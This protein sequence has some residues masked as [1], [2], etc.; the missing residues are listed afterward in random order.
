MKRL[1]ILL[2]L[3]LAALLLPARE[4]VRV[5]CIGNSITFGYLLNDPATESYPSQL[6]EMLGEGYEVGNFGRS[7]ATLLRHG[8]RPY[9]EQPEWRGALDFRPDIAVIHLG[10]NDTDPRNWVHY[11]DEFIGDYLAIIDTLR[12]QNPDVRIILA[13]LT[14]IGAQHYRFRSGTRQ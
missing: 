3:L 1:T 10:V 12:Q 7:G 8:H 4:P 5:A 2:P 6:Q 13:N 14:P 9:V 11:G